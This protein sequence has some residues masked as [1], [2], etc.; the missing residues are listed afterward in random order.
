MNQNSF[1]KDS[2][3]NPKILMKILGNPTPV[4]SPKMQSRGSANKSRKSNVEVSNS[5]CKQHFKEVHLFC[6]T[7]MQYL[8]SEC[9]VCSNHYGH[10]ILTLKESPSES[11]QSNSGKKY[12][13]ITLDITNLKADLF[14]KSR[15][16]Q[17]ELENHKSKMTNDAILFFSDL[18]GKV[19]KEKQN[20]LKNIN[21]HFERTFRIFNKKLSSI[22]LLFKDL[23]HK[24]DFENED[25]KNKTISSIEKLRTTIANLSFSVLEKEKMQ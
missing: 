17:K 25:F 5:Y 3:K 14:Q 19:E 1:R 4:K 22:D 6:N 10:K 13:S 20:S 15:Q 8:C 2:Q 16:V 9:I 12:S 18:S 11:T 7:C 23:E 21:E 24:S